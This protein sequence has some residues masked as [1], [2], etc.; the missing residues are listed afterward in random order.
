MSLAGLGKFPELSWIIPEWGGG[1]APLY[2]DSQTLAGQR[3]VS[4]SWEGAVVKR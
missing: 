3:G 2:V 1:K 4:E